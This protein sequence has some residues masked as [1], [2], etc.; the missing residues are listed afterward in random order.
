MSDGTSV[1]AG[2]RARTD[3]GYGSV[4]AADADL[5]FAG[6]GEMRA[7]CR[8]TD[9]AATPLGAS[10]DWPPAL[11]TAVR[12]MLA[13]P[14]ATSLWCG[15]S[16]TLL[17]N[18]TYQ[19]IL[20]VKHPGALGRS[21]AGVWDE[22]W[23]E[24]EPQFAAV[25]T[26]GEAVYEDES[27]LRMERLEGGGVD[28]A[29]FTYAL[30]PLTDED[31]A[32]LGVYNVAVEIT[33]KIRAREA[34]ESLAAQL[35]DQQVELELSNQQLQ[36]TAAEL[37][38]QA[39][40]LQSQAALLEE[41]TE[42]SE[43][44]RRTA[45]YERARAAG[46]LESMA[47]AHFVL[48]ADF[49]IAAVN[50]A[51][52]R[53]VGQTRDELLGHVMW[54]AFPGTAGTVFEH[55]YRAA[56]TVG[57]EAHFTHDYQ[58]AR[59]DLV[60]EVDIYPA[61][62][63]G[64]AVF[65]R[66][67]TDRERDRAAMEESNAR[68]RTLFESIDE[69]FCVVEMIFDDAGRAVDYRFVEAN[70]A[71]G[72]QTGLVDAVGHTARELIPTLEEHWFETYGRVAT[73]GEAIRFENGSEPMDRW[74]SVFAFRAGA[75]EERKV[76]L[77]FTD[78]TA[79][80]LAYREHAR[81]LAELTAQRQ[82][83]HALILHMPAP[84][85]LLTGPEHRHE[86]VNDAFRRI[87]GGGRDVTGLTVR[88]AFPELEGQG[89]YE[90]F[91]QVWQTGQP[92]SAPEALVRYDRDGTGVQDTWFDVRFQPVRDAEGNVAG[93]LNFGVDVSGQ[94]LARHEVERLLEISERARAEAEAAQAEAENARAEAEN[95]RADAEAA[96]RA[97]GEFLAVMSHELR[98]PLNAIGGY[99]ELLE[100]GI[101]GPV[102]PQ[103]GDDLRRIQ[104]SQRHLLGLINEVLNYAKLETGSVHY[105]LADVPVREAVAAAELLVAPQARGKGLA[106][107][108]GECPRELA[109]RADAEKLRQI[110]VNLL[111]NAIKFT[112]PG[113]R[114]EI[115]CA[116]M[117][118]RVAVSVAD[119]G[120]GIAAEKME[121]IFDPFVQ[122]RSDLTRPHEGTGLGLAI[123][124]DLARGMGGELTATSTPGVGSVFTLSLPAA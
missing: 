104:T 58:D 3:F 69:G 61:P 105:D 49:R 121:E 80:R 83:L 87:S 34:N 44:A 94:V 15:A 96:N 16:Y 24:L 11:R 20:G 32:C 122:V 123:S 5:L 84:L 9:W 56:S 81:L 13:A 42:E 36:D 14:V 102:T 10:V 18:D 22:L 65:W 54:D 103:Q 40:E 6:P 66:D 106:L 46:I 41:R 111:S 59:L 98:T 45:E 113:G 97:K 93:I 99:A 60:T 119:T 86:I 71:F 89:I 21:G 35:Q 27:L 108:V 64:V 117:D 67:V 109:A 124:R 17:Y 120:M 79:T 115:T 91:D 50:A 92:W 78:T 2:G 85:A 53:N 88:E 73:T 82:R 101:R 75:P 68:Y 8:A 12:L 110:L 77:L 63:G 29:W 28:D 26:R 47:D 52:E 114:I 62:A 31:G 55:H 19:R 70:P 90:R 33:E 100:M 116:R 30:S 107:E 4:D 43:A 74:F 76:A 38:L 112:D 25:R 57:A 48:D 37:E 39:E 7:R 1:N 23:P 118:G 51:M 72:R 95:A